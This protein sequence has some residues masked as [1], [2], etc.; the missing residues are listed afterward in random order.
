MK[1]VIFDMDGLMVDTERVY[2]QF[3]L[4][5]FPQTSLE[6]RERDF[7]N[8]C[9]RNRRD[10][11]AYLESRFPG[12]DTDEVL[13]R[14]EGDALIHIRQNGVPLK[15]GLLELFEALERGGIPKAL[16][17]SATAED[18]EMV[19]R[20]AGIWNRFAVRVFGD[21]VKNSKPQPDIF[22]LAAQQAGVPPEQCMVLE[23]SVAGVTAARRAGMITV[24]VPDLIQPDDDIK[25]I[26]DH[27]CESLLD[28]IALIE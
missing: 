26:L 14:V 1:L 17:T 4:R 10:T 11:A 19:L 21:M 23:D 7:Y 18:A 8:V 25:R 2:L 20:G 5:G 6:E 9:G 3:W 24:M 16:A 27:Q 28:A 22:L 12:I 13:D 15:K